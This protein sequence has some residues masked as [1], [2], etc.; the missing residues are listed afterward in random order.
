MDASDFDPGRSLRVKIEFVNEIQR[1]LFG[2]R[3]QPF[4]KWWWE[5]RKA[6][7]LWRSLGYEVTAYY[8]SSR[9]VPIADA[10]ANIN[11][12][13]VR[14]QPR[15]QRQLRPRRGYDHVR[16]DNCHTGR[17]AAALNDSGVPDPT[18]V[19]DVA[20]DYV[21]ELTVDNGQATSTPDRV[22]VSA[23]F[24]DVPPHAEA[25]RDQEIPQGTIVALDG[26]GSDDPGGLPGLFPG[27]RRPAP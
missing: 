9:S 27:F 22:T 6:A 25:G 4:W 19:P 11:A 17:G 24:I 2:E 16:L 21:F 1:R 12:L 14:S 8:P 23:A 15:R 3:K 10:G 18:F 13:S 26:T 7:A 5:Y 20:G